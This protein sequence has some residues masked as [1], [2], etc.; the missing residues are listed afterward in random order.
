MKPIIKVI[1]LR[2]SEDEWHEIVIGNRILLSRLKGDGMSWSISGLGLTKNERFIFQTRL[3]EFRNVLSIYL[4]KLIIS[5]NRRGYKK[6][7]SACDTVW[8]MSLFKWVRFSSRHWMN[9]KCKPWCKRTIS[10]IAK[11]FRFHDEF[12]FALYRSFESP[13][14]FESDMMTAFQLASNYEAD[15]YQSGT[16]LYS[17]L[18]LDFETN[19][20][21]AKRCL[22]AFAP[23]QFFAN[24]DLDDVKL[25]QKGQQK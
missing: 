9:Y 24:A 22:G 12:E 25:I 15:L 7:L 14:R 18:G 17:P 8:E 16:L 21:M 10:K 19:R 4:G 13:I 2:F 20:E 3:F 5:Y 6:H 23:V 1:K 11:E